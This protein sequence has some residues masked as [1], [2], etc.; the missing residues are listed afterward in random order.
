MFNIT[1]RKDTTMQQITTHRTIANALI[2]LAVILTA[3]T[4]GGCRAYPSSLAGMVVGDIVSD[5]DVDSRKSKLLGQPETATTR[6][7]RSQTTTT[8]CI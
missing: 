4:A 6:L 1:N 5:V 3:L 7:L 2:G 8:S